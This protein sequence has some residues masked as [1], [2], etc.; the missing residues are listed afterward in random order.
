MTPIQKMRA[1]AEAQALLGVSAHAS[2][3]ELHSA[4]RK[5]MFKMHP[6]RGLGTTADV[7]KINAAYA[8]LRDRSTENAEALV[9]AAAAPRVRPTRPVST[10]GPRPTTRV[11]SD[12]VSASARA[13]CKSMLG[14]SADGH[15]PTRIE[16]QGRA[17]SYVVDGALKPGVNRVAVPTGYLSEGREGT[18][19]MVSFRAETAGKGRIVVPERVRSER[20]PGASRV[21]I[22]FTREAS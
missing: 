20:F 15:V 2:L 17:I 21:E 22:R 6:D 14:T 16:R 13:Y 7:H 12:D 9:Q 19:T 3:A 18:P 8:L 10:M 11:R 4:W 1:V 5:M